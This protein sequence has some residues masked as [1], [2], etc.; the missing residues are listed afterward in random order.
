MNTEEIAV[1]RLL[2]ESFTHIIRE[3]RIDQRKLEKENRKLRR[4]IEQLKKETK[5]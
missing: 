2:K 3:L 5:P 4:E 1:M